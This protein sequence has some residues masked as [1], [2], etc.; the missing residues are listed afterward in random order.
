MFQTTE[1][2]RK[3]SK[4]TTVFQWFYKFNIFQVFTPLASILIIFSTENTKNLP[5]G[6]NL[7]SL[8]PSWRDLDSPFGFLGASW[9]PL[10]PP[11]KRDD[12]LQSTHISKG[13]FGES[14]G[15]PAGAR[16]KRVPECSWNPPFPARVHRMTWVA[17]GKLPQIRMD[18]WLSP[19]PTIHL[20]WQAGW[21]GLARAGQ[22]WAGLAWIPEL[23]TLR[24]WI[25]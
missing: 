14:L 20:P 1:K 7:A 25:Y 18:L 9:G 4:K 21:V 12:F 15:A 5:Q 2:H 6:Y 11:L 23:S 13:R 24:G 8:D 17:Q 10:G 19:L 3:S 22:G 16:R